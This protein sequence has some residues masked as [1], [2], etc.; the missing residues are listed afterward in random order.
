MNPS[1]ITYYDLVTLRPLNEL[2][3]IDDPDFTLQV[4]RNYEADADAGRISEDAP[5]A[6]GILHRREGETV[7][8]D[9]HG[10]RLTLRILKVVKHP[11]SAATSA[12]NA[13]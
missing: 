6:R 8:I 7:A 10:R 9:V 11:V 5:L 2:G 3:A 4:V 1:S 12:N 13:G